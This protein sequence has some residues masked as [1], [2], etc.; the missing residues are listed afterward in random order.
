MAASISSGKT[1]LTALFA[2]GPL[3]LPAQASADPSRRQADGWGVG[4]V[5]PDGGIAALER[6]ASPLADA[7]PSFTRTLRR[8]AGPGTLI[9]H[10]RDASNPLG[11]SRARLVRP[12]NNHPFAGEGL[13]FAHNGTLSICPEIRENLGSCAA[14]LR[15]ASDSEVL[16]WQLV[17]MRDAYGDLAL[18]VEMALDEIW[19]VWGSCSG[20]RPGVK[21][22]Y[23]GLNIF[24]SDGSRLCVLCHYPLKKKKD[25]LLTPG[26]D[27]GEIAWRTS[28]G[29]AVFSSEP[30]DAGPW[31]RLREGELA[32][33]VLSGGKIKVSVRG[34]AAARGKAALK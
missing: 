6:S 4:R 32:D 7:V 3:S 19:T 24:V 33:A 34:I 8:A 16:F 18:A 2:G 25:S 15:G 10:V 22:P 31:R 1:D 20:D 9:A 17:K 28:P 30:L 14:R 29:G 12:E 23:R 5:A 13:L 27:W 11:L 26:W 21:A